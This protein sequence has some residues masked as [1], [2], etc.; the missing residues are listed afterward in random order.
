MNKV[1][2]YLFLFIGLAALAFAF[3]VGGFDG[4]GFRLDTLLRLGGIWPLL[5][6][7]VCLFL[8]FLMLRKKAPA[9]AAP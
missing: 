1:F 4:N 5:G 3:M 2:G 6:G 7:M 9:A 8:S